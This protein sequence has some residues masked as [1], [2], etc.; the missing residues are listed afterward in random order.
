MKKIIATV[1]AT[2]ALVTLAAS[3]AQAAT[4]GPGKITAY[5]KHY[6]PTQFEINLSNQA[7]NVFVWADT[8][9]VDCRGAGIS[10]GSLISMTRLGQ[11]KTAGKYITINTS[12]SYPTYIVC[13]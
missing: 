4:F 1:V 3:P 7:A 2:G 8:Y 11:I 5:Y 12:Y 13:W 9:F 6:T 10:D